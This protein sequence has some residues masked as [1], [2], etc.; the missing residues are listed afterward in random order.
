M[1]VL[2]LADLHIG[3]KLRDFSLIDD[4]RKALSDALKAAKKEE[5]DAIFA[6]GDI[7]DSG[8]P[9]GEAVSLL[10]S[11]LEEC[12]DAKMPLFLIPGNHDNAEKLSYVNWSLTKE[13]IHLVTDLKEAVKPIPLGDADI[14]CL[15]YF[16]YG[17]VNAAFD[18][19]NASLD[20]A[21]QSLVSKMGLNKDRLNILIYHGAILPSGSDRLHLSGSESILSHE[22]G[23]GYVADVPTINPS[24]LAPFDF[25]ALGHIHKRQKVADN[26]MYAGSLLK[27]HKDEWKDDKSF[28]FLDI[29][30]GKKP[31]LTTHPFKPLHDVIVVRGYLDDIKKGDYDHDAYA[32]FVLNDETPRLNAMAELRA[33][34]FHLA[35]GLEYSGGRESL[36]A[37]TPPEVG[38]DIS[39]KDA[40][41]EFFKLV[42]GHEANEEQK[43][44]V[45]G[46][47]D[48][49]GG[50]AE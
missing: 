14:Y 22:D 44:V 15:P 31:V 33:A 35:A 45:E 41:Y 4:Q 1:K 47:F 13:G 16:R 7:Y 12:A 27:Y 20:E 39:K 11:F 29:E 42:R 38:E 5:A 2:L 21:F 50:D 18:E 3:K 26:A 25:V 43:K 36:S 48:E 19:E 6:A 49:E 17:E 40:F 46:I 37:E 9:S 10:D 8:T 28:L 24:L 34:G 30:K 23:D 32:Y